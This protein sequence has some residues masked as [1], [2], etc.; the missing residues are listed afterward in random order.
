MYNSSPFRLVGGCKDV[1]VVLGLGGAPVGLGRAAPVDGLFDLG[2]VIVGAMRP[3]SVAAFREWHKFRRLTGLLKLR[4][5]L[6]DGPAGGLTRR[7]DD[8]ATPDSVT[9][10]EGAPSLCIYWKLSD[11]TTRLW[12]RLANWVDSPQDAF[13]LRGNSR[14]MCLPRASF[15]SGATSSHASS[16]GS[17]DDDEDLRYRLADCSTR[18]S[19]SVEVCMF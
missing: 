1:A 18:L 12:E 14:S 9:A 4:R 8:A 2:G 6:F 5:L 10:C 7:R 11:Y 3:L 15:F 16:H 17:S 19:M 13:L